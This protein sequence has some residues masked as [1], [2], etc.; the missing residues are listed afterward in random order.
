MFGVSKISISFGFSAILFCLLNGF[1]YIWEFVH[2][3]GVYQLSKVYD[4][5]R[6]RI[7]EFYILQD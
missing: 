2:L 1:L 4:S 5:C 3:F 7:G 6:V